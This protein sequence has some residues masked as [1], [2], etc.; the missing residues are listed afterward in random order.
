MP[1]AIQLST[2]AQEIPLKAATAVGRVC[3]CHV[4]PPSDDLTMA[5]TDPSL[6]LVAASLPT[7]VQTRDVGQD[8]AVASSIPFC[9]YFVFHVAPRFTV[10][11]MVAIGPYAP[12]PTNMQS[13]LLEHVIDPV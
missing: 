1:M 4:T 6:P 2:D 3:A 11:E 9:R 8:A 7:T 13:V 12:K 5:A 10:V